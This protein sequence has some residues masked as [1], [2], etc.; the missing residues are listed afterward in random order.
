MLKGVQRLRPA[1]WFRKQRRLVRLIL[2]LTAILFG[3]WLAGFGIGS[4]M[5]DPTTEEAREV[6]RRWSPLLFFLGCPAGV[7]VTVAGF[8]ML[9]RSFRAAEG[10]DQ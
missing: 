3:V 1:R 10:N 5:G 2:S 4:M 6:Q 9:A 7:A 8:I